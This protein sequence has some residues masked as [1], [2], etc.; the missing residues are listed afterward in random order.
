MIAL[1]LTFLAFTACVI[2]GMREFLTNSL[3]NILVFLV[4]GASILFVFLTTICQYNVILFDVGVFNTIMLQVMFASMPLLFSALIAGVVAV[5]VPEFDIITCFSVSYFV[6]TYLLCR[7]R[8]LW[9][10]GVVQ[11]GFRI[12]R[13]RRAQSK[14]L[15]PDAL[16][17][18]ILVIPV[19]ISVAVHVAIH[20]RLPMTDSHRW[21][22][23]AYAL[24]LPRFLMSFC[25]F[26]HKERVVDDVRA[27][28]AGEDF[29]STMTILAL[30][31]FLP[32]HPIFDELKTFCTAQEPIPS[33]VLNMMG[34][35][36]AA[37][38]LTQRRLRELRTMAKQGGL[39]GGGDD[40][41]MVNRNV[42]Q[43][44]STSSFGYRL[45]F[46]FFKLLMDILI[47][48]TTIFACF[49]LNLDPAVLPITIFGGVAL[50]ELYHKDD[51]NLASLFMLAMVG[52]LTT[53]IAF[54]TFADST[55]AP[56]QYVLTGLYDLSL[57]DFSQVAGVL[58]TLAA[59]APSLISLVDK[60]TL[61]DLLLPHAGSSGHGSSR[62]SSLQLT[63]E[64][65][66]WAHYLYSIVFV[67][68][69]LVTVFLE[70]LILDQVRVSVSV[71]SLPLCV[72]SLYGSC[73]I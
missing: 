66:A 55:V 53:T 46:G 43:T 56:L 45:Q 25:V 20:R 14:P 9:R 34:S 67:V 19:F 10:G 60:E 44:L 47:A 22:H 4:M 49:L 30:G 27:Y 39:V 28:H 7:P 18:A 29:F 70:L 36:I 8:L 57:Y 16:L 54:R 2:W 59:I 40:L 23:F 64:M 3:S 6:Y 58:L 68:I 12:T 63:S 38:V 11:Q 52:F 31:H 73:V 37:A 50:N 15:L 41:G 17:R 21:F 61:H 51:W 1:S 32:S 65:I 5:E 13:E 35:M 48:M 33:R 72:G 24:L 62:G 71:S 42:Q 26:D 69:T